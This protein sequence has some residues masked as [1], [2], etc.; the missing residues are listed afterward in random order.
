MHKPLHGLLK[1]PLI[2]LQVPAKADSFYLIS[3]EMFFIKLKDCGKK[4]HYLLLQSKLNVN[5]YHVKE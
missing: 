3:G 1:L 2:F 5:E 4:R